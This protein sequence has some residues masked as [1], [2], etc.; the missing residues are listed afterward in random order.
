VS[1]VFGTMAASDRI[2]EGQFHMS[3][4]ARVTLGSMALALAS[5]LIAGSAETAAIRMTRASDGELIWI[6]DIILAA[7]LGLVSY[8]W[9][10]LRA[11]RTSL[12][13]LEREQIV[14]DTELSI[15]ADIQRRL[16]PPLP[17]AAGV[18]YAARLQ[19]AGKIGGDFYDFVQPTADLMLLLVGDLSG[20]GVPAAMM[21]ASSRALFRT[22]ARDIQDPS[23]LLR[24][25]S[26]VLYDENRGTSYLTCFLAAFDAKRKTLTYVNA[27]HP[28]ALLIRGSTHRA[29]AVGGPPAGMF[30]CSCYSSATLPLDPRDVGIV[31]TD[32]VTEAIEREG[33]HADALISHAVERLSGPLTPD[34]VCDAVM[35][36]AAAGAGPDGVEGWHDDRT[37][38]AFMLEA[39]S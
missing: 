1:A 33:V 6:S 25:L 7:T 28:A 19:P 9:L 13:Q 32:G 15:A 39:A 23:L 34:R 35:Q 4:Q 2:P 26:D 37:V 11:A 29:L 36:L 18:R 20:K 24:R 5:Y 8:L 30:P 12:M 3:G 31:V 27:G 10:N 38:V 14:L 22:L 16:L 17:A 21:L